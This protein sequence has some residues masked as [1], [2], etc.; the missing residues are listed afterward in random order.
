MNNTLQSIFYRC[1]KFY[2]Y[3]M[4]RLL[5]SKHFVLKP[6]YQLWKQWIWSEKENWRFAS[7]F[8]NL[9][10][11]KINCTPYFTRVFE[12]NETLYT[13]RSAFPDFQSKRIQSSFLLSF[14]EHDLHLLKFYKK[15][16]WLQGT[17]VSVTSKIKFQNAELVDERSLILTFKN[18]KLRQRLIGIF[19]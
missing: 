5:Y 2:H 16:K 17:R 4:F 8:K 13:V 7:K 11:S 15:K 1:T 19:V 9:R 3:F 10:N 14:F 6:M 18:Q 12:Q